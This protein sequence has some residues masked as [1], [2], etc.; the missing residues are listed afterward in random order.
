MASTSGEDEAATAYKLHDKFYRVT[1][2][3]PSIGGQYR[4]TFLVPVPSAL[5]KK[6]P[7]PQCRYFY[8]SIFRRYAVLLQNLL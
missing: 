6:V 5:W 8:F 1:V 3:D 7:V 2:W 4:G